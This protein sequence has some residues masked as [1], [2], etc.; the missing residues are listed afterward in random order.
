MSGEAGSFHIH[1][2]PVP[3]RINHDDA[4]CGQTGGH[5]NPFGVDKSGSPPTGHS[6]S[7]KYEVGD[8]SGKYGNLKNRTWVKGSFVDPS[9]RLFGRWSVIGR[10]VVIHHAPIPHRWVCANVE[11]DGPDTD[12]MT[13]VAEFTYPVA[14]RVIFR[15]VKLRS[16]RGKTEK[17][18]KRSNK[19][20]GGSCKHFRLNM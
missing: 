11:L 20:G 16:F 5:Y 3:P 18:L 9:V 13:A 10:S 19:R 2:F 6:S 7:D 4:P 8:L 14:G 15:W 1:K 17:E 12:V